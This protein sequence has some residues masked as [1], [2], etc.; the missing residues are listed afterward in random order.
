MG[1]RTR[2][3]RA[4]IWSIRRAISHTDSPKD[5]E[6][7]EHTH[8]IVLW[9]SKRPHRRLALPLSSQGQLWALFSDGRLEHWELLGRLVAVRRVRRINE[10]CCRCGEVGWIMDL[11]ER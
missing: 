1:E 10:M 5:A 11:R 7:V 6:E 3:K 4:H 8:L 2:A 9:F